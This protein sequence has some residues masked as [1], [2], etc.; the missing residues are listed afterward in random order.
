MISFQLL[1][2]EGQHPP[3]HPTLATPLLLQPRMRLVPPVLG[4][5]SGAAF[6][7][8]PSPLQGS[9]QLFSHS[10]LVPGTV[11]GQVQ[12]LALGFIELHRVLL[13]PL[14]VT[15]SFMSPL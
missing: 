5:S 4:V 15:C 11:P 9:S 3:S 7:P 1:R 10:V 2:D 8:P 13:V 12:P 6:P 14:D